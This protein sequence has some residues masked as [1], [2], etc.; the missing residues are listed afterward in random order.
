[1]SI[2]SCLKDV[3]KVTEQLDEVQAALAKLSGK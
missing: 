2:A 3:K 1:M